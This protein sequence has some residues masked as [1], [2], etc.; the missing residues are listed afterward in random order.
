VAAGVAAFAGAFTA[1]FAA[2]FGG[3]SARSGVVSTSNAMA[4]V[5]HTAKYNLCFLKAFIKILLQ[6]ESDRAY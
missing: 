2:G 6:N 5:K 4:C 1:G 3:S